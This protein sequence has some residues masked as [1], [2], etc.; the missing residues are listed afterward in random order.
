MRIVGGTLSGRRFAGPPGDVTRPTSDRVREAIASS[1]ESRGGFGGARVLDL[2]A[3]TGAM[4][5]E[6]LSRGA[7]HAVLVERDAKVAA[8]IKKAAAELGLPARCT[9]VVADLSSE[10]ALARIDAA[11]HGPFDRVFADPPYADIALV[12][13]L[14]VRLREKGLL[15]P[16]AILAVEHA[17]RHAPTRPEGFSIISEPRYGDTGVLLLTVD[18]SEDNA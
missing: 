18:S 12:A 13:P 11:G 5:F 9:I 7:S 4:A 2:F 6:A 17:K 10:G 8:A 16:E 14:L 15:A 3:G 1:I